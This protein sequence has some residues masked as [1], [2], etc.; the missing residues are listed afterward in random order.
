MLDLDDPGD[1]GA[2]VLELSSYQLETVPSLKLGAG[3]IIN[4]T[5]DHL[6]LPLR[7]GGI[8]HRQT[9]LT[10]AIIPEGLLVL[11]SDDA[12]APLQGYVLLAPSVLMLILLRILKQGY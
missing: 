2:I 4:I 7:L 8:C 9:R 1:G 3:A 6:D 11:G 10:E 12:L 5:P